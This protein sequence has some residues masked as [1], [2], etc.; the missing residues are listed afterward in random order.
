MDGLPP[1]LWLQTQQILLILHRQGNVLAA[2]VPSE[3]P[4]LL[5]PAEELL[6]VLDEELHD[7]GL[8]SD[9]PERLLAGQ[10]GLVSRPEQVGGP[11]QGQVPAGHPGLVAQPGEQVEVG[12]Q[13]GEG[14]EVG[15]AQAVDG[16]PHHL[17]P[18]ARL[19]PHGSHQV[20][21]E[22]VAA[23]WLRQLSEIQLEIS[24]LISP[25]RKVIG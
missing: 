11:D 21:V 13:V 15:R 10:P 16:L 4:G 1:P 22:A 5:L 17:L 24:T 18:P 6:V 12:Q 14:G 7:P 19:G 3:P 25:Q 2:Q 8:H 20:G 23:D 9:V